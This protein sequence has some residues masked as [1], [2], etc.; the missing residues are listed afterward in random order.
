MSDNNNRPIGFRV[1]QSWL[2]LIEGQH[3]LTS[4]EKVVILHSEILKQD[5]MH[6][7]MF[8]ISSALLILSG[9]NVG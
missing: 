5:C 3:L 2:V 7:D 4:L 1:G 9:L 6:L 8:W